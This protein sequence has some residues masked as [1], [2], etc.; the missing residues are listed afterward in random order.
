MAS[1]HVSGAV[2]LLLQRH[3]DWSAAEVKAALTATARPVAGGDGVGPTRAGAGLVDVAAADTP[4]L[5]PTP[6][7]VSFGLVR[8]ETITSRSVAVEDAGAERAN[9]RCRSS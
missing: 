2:A 1:P 8:S 9:G 4:V 5:R 7:A 6:T 3:P